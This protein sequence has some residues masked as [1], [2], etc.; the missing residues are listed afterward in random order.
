MLTHFYP[1]ARAFL[2]YGGNLLKINPEFKNLI[3][4]LT[5]E[6]YE[7][8]KQSILKEGC[9]DSIVVW[10]NTIVDGHNRYEICTENNIK[11]KTSETIF[12]S[13][14]SAREWIIRN[15]FGRRNLS[16][17][18]R[19]ILALQLKSVIAGRAKE[20][21]I[22]HGKTAPGKT[23]NQ[24]SDEVNTAKELAKIAGVSHDTIQRVETIQRELPKEIH[25]NIKSGKISINE[26]YKSIKIQKAKEHKKETV[27]NLSKNNSEL[28]EG[29]GAF[30]IILADPPWKYENPP[31]GHTTRAIENHYPTMFL[32]EICG[33]P[34]HKIA[35]KDSVLFLWTTSPKLEESLRVISSWGFKYR[36]SFVW[37][38]DKIGMGYYC[39]A[40]HEILLVAKKGELPMPETKNRFSSVISAPRTKHSEKPELVYEIIEKMYPEYKKIELFSR[41]KREGWSAWGNQANEE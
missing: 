24:K 13:I 34:V 39:R 16:A 27:I 19:S 29:L 36:T 30:N 7:G 3:P 9:R 40:Q 41:K 33:L 1:S 31:M 25:D 12:D 4:P 14:F 10:N 37:I 18:D 32:E 11:Y 26:A 8:L 17:Y 28:N 5:P 6:E 15:Q 21:Q 22:E 20:K 23:L 2:F 38:K 35:E